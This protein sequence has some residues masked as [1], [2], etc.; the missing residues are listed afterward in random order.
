MALVRLRLWFSWLSFGF[1]LHLG[2]VSAWL[3]LG[4][5]L[6]FRL[7]FQ[8]WLSFSRVLAGFDFIYV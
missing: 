8:L 2:L 1:W 6:G 3:W 5:R 4:F 7:G